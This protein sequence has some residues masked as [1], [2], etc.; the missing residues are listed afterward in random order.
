M[1]REENIG[2]LKELG[3]R[4]MEEGYDEI[5]EEGRRS[6]KVPE[7]ILSDFLC[8]EHGYR[9]MKSCLY[10]MKQ[11]CFPCGKELNDFDFSK[12]PVNET[13]IRYLHE[14]EFLKENMNVI[15][16]GGSGTGKT[17]LATSIGIG[18]VRLGKKVLFC[19]LV[20]LANELEKEKQKGQN[21]KLVRKMLNKDCCILDELGYLPFSRTGAQ[22]LFHTISRLYEHVSLIIT[23]NLEFGEWPQVFC[24]AK[25]TTAMLDRLTHHCEIIETGNESYRLNWRLSQQANEG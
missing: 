13:Q 16:I 5:M 22:L 12:S 18:L 1:A 11:A 21:G 14:G 17:H 15:F 9:Q 25:M 7:R 4:G 2:L 3:L 8:A 6:R 10:R 20:D 19:N 23:T 24:D